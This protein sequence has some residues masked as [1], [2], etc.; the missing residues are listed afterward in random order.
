[1]YPINSPLCTIGQ[2]TLNNVILEMESMDKLKET[3]I[4]PVGLAIVLVLFSIL[5]GLNLITLTLFWFV[6]T[7]GL[8]I[9]LPTKIS[10]NK[11]HLFGSLVG[12]LIFY[13][14]IV[15]MIYDHYKTDYFKIMI[16]SCALNLILV[17][18][19][20]WTRRSRTGAIKKDS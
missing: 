8:T 20:T 11:N 7:P 2:R 17:S 5:I 15:F 13:A 1:M 12:L 4:V 19:I 6:I 9:Y 10:N 16:L 18:V 3:L 14:T